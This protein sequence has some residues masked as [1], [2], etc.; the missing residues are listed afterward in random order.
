MNRNFKTSSMTEAA[1]ITGILVIFAYLT[2]FLLPSLMFFYPIPAIILAKRK[3]LKYSVLSLIAASII[4]SMLLGI[5]TG[6]YF[7]VLFTPFGIALSYGICKE[8]NPY[9]TIMLG[10]IAFM[11]SFA[12]MILFTQAIMGVNYIQQMIEMFDKTVV[13]YKEMMNKTAAN[14]D[15]GKLNEAIKKIDDMSIVMKFMLSQLL[16]ALLIV[17]SVITSALNYFVVSKLGNRFHIDIKK[18]EGLSLFSFPPTFIVA[19]AVLLL[20]SFLLGIFK[21]NVYAI[22]M[23]IFMIS[24]VAMFLQG[25]AVLKFYLLKLNINKIARTLIIIMVIFM[26]EAG[27]LLALVGIIDLIFDLRKIRHKVV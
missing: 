27:I 19:M 12:V 18:H 21:I 16:P 11:I 26:A 3:G 8:E 17:T 2:W 20:L 24:F 13:M 14:I 9:K 4:I 7:L 25:F 10:A 15:A 6:I 1:M 23:N 22:Q 5:Q